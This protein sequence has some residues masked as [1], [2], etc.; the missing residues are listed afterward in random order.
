M[1]K[2]YRDFL[3]L[4][5]FNEEEIERLL[6]DWIEGS[7]K[8]GLEED[9]VAYALNEWIPKH[10]DIQ[11]LGVRKMIGAYIREAIELS[12]LHQ[13]KKDGV[14]I[15]YGIIPAINTN[16]LGMKYAGK[17]NI[18][19]SFPDIHLVTILNGFFHKVNS[20]LDKAEEEGMTYGCRHCALNKT[21]I[22]AKADNIIPSPDVIW[23]WG[24]NCDEGPKT[25]EYIAGLYGDDWR[26]VVSRIPH[27][28][29]FGYI[30][31]ED[32]DRV[33]YLGEVLRE[34]QREIEGI[35]GITASDEDM[36]QA[37]KDQARYQF[38]YGQLVSLVCKSNPQVLSGSA[39]TNFGQPISIP[40]N[41][42][43]QYMEE[44]LDIMLKECKQARKAGTGVLP[45]DAPK[46]GSYFVPFAIPWVDKIFK[47]NGIGTTFS[48]TFTPAKSQL[49]PSR[50]EEPF[51]AIAE[52][53][54]KM[55]FGQNMGYEVANMIEK[56][57]ASK[58][59][60]GLLLGFFDFDRWL[61]AHHKMAAKMIEE[62]TDVPTFYMESDF[63]D[64][65]DYSEEALRT[66]IESIAQIIK[67]RKEQ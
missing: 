27:D 65:R 16:Y 3:E 11:Y 39:V 24:L 13:Y 61:G 52:S 50:Y 29:P 42:G 40:F 1:S 21:R 23:S 57:E 5:A 6:P 25:D 10:W 15:V 31:D 66:R 8:L 47:D 26:Y 49:K 41:S 18:F 28:T 34:S 2:V 4:C 19:V 33:E 46:L 22:G 45:K 36:K 20:Y 43:V 54:L 60:D 62:A 56:V 63:W 32:D 17:D 14:K 7:K 12:K 53:W 67:L 58:P 9:D 48:L 59:F 51:N 64:D 37:I 30:D 44:A 35:T 55:P 38:K